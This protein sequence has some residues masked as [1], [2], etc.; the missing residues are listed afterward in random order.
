[1]SGANGHSV[2]SF[3]SG[4]LKW[5]PIL[6]A[7][8][9]KSLSYSSLG[10]KMENLMGLLS[11]FRPKKALSVVFSRNIGPRFASWQVTS[12]RKCLLPSIQDHPFGFTDTF[13]I[14][15]WKCSYRGF[16][17]FWIPGSICFLNAFQCEANLYLMGS[18]SL[19]C[20]TLGCGE[21]LWTP[22]VASQGG[23]SNP[24][25]LSLIESLLTPKK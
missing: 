14:Q 22:V 1:M 15:W 17:T 20:F 9:W 25:G 6:A 10:C 3:S 21:E 4:H 16:I 8:I 7:V 13:P 12:L 23:W 5:F 2:A 11:Y 19:L 18:L 24:K